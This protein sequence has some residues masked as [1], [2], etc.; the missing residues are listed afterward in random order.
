MPVVAPASGSRPFDRSA[1][2]ILAFQVLHEVDVQFAF[3]MVLLEA[4][5]NLQ[6]E[7]HGTG[8]GLVVSS[9]S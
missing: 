6:G 2:A 3:F 9:A 8:L 7:L 1:G 5:D 4:M